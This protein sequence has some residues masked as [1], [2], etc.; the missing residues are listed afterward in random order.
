MCF[1]FWWEQQRGD[2]LLPCIF[3]ALCDAV[4][5]GHER[6]L[7]EQ[8]QVYTHSTKVEITSQREQGWK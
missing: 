1:D 4:T 8:P 2:F 7:S 6:D 5:S 3:K